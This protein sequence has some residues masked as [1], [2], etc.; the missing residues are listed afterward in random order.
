MKTRKSEL[1]IL[2]PKR[3]P[4]PDWVWATPFEVEYSLSMINEGEDAEC[5]YLSRDEY[6]ALKHY[7]A[8]VRNYDLDS[9]K[10]RTTGDAL[11]HHTELTLP[12]RAPKRKGA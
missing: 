10:A 7:L 3:D 1:R 6:I 4:T 9:V 5:I 8:R 11:N 2:E 12:Q